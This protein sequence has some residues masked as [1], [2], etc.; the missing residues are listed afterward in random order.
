MLS[1]W[2]SV[3]LRSCRGLRVK[4]DA[5]WQETPSLWR[6]WLVSAWPSPKWIERP[7]GDEG[8]S[9]WRDIL[10]FFALLPVVIWLRI[11]FLHPPAWAPANGLASTATA[12]SYLTKRS[13]LSLELAKQGRW[14]EYYADQTSRFLQ[15]Q[16]SR[17]RSSGR[18]S[19]RSAACLKQAVRA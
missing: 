1:V 2:T 7:E 19:W 5:T 8:P 13:M 6:A 10:V 4:Y 15:A 9:L 18:G 16:W 17:I 3:S 14:E 12:P 11:N